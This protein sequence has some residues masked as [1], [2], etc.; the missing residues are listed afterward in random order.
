MRLINLCPWVRFF[1]AKTCDP[2]SILRSGVSCG[3][4]LLVLFPAPR[5]FSPGTPVFPSPQKP[6]FISP[7]RP[8]KLP[9]LNCIPC[10]NKVSLPLPFTFTL[11]ISIFPE[12]FTCT[13]QTFRRCQSM[14]KV[15]LAQGVYWHTVNSNFSSLWMARSQS[16]NTGR[17]YPV[18]QFHSTNT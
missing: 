1:P 11:E 7:T 18:K 17:F 9:A 3:L 4:S 14:Q 12:A 13:P 16:R 2:G 8:H 10:I 5:G 6:T 15:R